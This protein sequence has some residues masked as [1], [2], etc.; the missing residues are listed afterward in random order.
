MSPCAAIVGWPVEGPPRWTFT[1]TQG[2]SVIAAYPMFSIISEKPGPLVAVIALAPVHAAPIT[3]AMLAISSSIWM[4][5]P[6]FFGSL[7]AICSATSVDGV[8]G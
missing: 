7:S 8:I 4:K 5:T 3:A 1:I 2:V 6:F